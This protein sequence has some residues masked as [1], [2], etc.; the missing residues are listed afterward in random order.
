MLFL[1]TVGAGY[2]LNAVLIEDGLT[3]TGSD[4][5]QI[6]AYSGG[7]NGPMDFYTVQPG[8]VPAE[9]MVL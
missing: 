5:D 4:W 7:G 2:K 8:A 6:N 9:I 1:E 3:G